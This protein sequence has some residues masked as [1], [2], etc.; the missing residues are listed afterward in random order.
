MSQAGVATV[1]TS[2]WPTPRR[3]RLTL[4]AIW[5]ATAALLL[6]A[7][8]AIADDREAIKAVR[9]DTAPSIV[10]AQDLYVHLAGLDTQLAAS[11]LGG[12]LDRDVADELFELERSV[13]TRR[14][15]DAADNITLG[16]AERIPI[17][18]MNE[19]LGR[20]L[21]LA[22]R[23]QSLYAGSDREGA[24]GLL[25][26]ATDLMHDRIL[27]QAA[28][29]DRVN[30]DDMD[31]RYASAQ[32]ASRLHD[33]EAIL[34][35]GLLV[36]ALASAQLFIRARMR[37]RIV[38]ALLVSTLLAAGF[39]VYLVG[40]FRDA[41]EDLRVARDDAFN[42]V[43]LLLRARAL[44]F[45]A[46][47]DED[48]YLLDHPRAGTY[49]SAFQVKTSQLS[50][51]AREPEPGAG[52]HGLLT[53]ELRN[54][55]FKGEAD[56]ARATLRELAGYAEVDARIRRLEGG[57][58]HAQAVDLAVGTGAGQVRAVFA[59]LDAALQRTTAINQ[60]AFD[61]VLAAADD[62]LRRAAWVD[63][64]LALVL[65]LAAWLG[66]RPRLREYSA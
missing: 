43:H 35:G 13:V 62:G 36:A 64:A 28:T 38:P 15:V 11:M 23:A 33:L 19:E 57:A 24:L 61:A 41:R 16:D 54:V 42:S 65:A 18:V 9:S 52:V 25:R 29:L 46:R 63:P 1:A 48:R 45:D 26:I 39:T 49:D 21:E 20:Y 55:T 32:K 4:F 51:S 44:A 2:R 10:A 14:L 12:A 56:A 53:D 30:R 5:L 3:L 27:P 17:V 37:R 50:S 58:Q 60:D 59:R 31:R 7:L 47:G 66:I 40:R 34:T 8:R 6:V 22:S